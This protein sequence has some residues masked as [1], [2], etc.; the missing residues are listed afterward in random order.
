[1]NGSVTYIYNV[2][3]EMP[4]LKGII[5]KLTEE[6]I[7]FVGNPAFVPGLHIRGERRAS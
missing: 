5:K 3:Y 4:I 1:M 7:I 2:N 6:V